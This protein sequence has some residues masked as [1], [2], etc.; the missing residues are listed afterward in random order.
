MPI[1]DANGQKL[2]YEIHGEGEPLLCVMGLGADSRA[3]VLQAPAFSQRHRTIIFDNRDVGQSSYVP[4]GSYEI[5]DM[6]ADALALADALDLESFHLLGVSMGGAI[7]QEMA[8]AAP[9]R[10]KTL[11][12]AVTWSSGG[13]YAEAKSQSWG[14]DIQ[15]LTFEEQIESMLLVLF[16]EAFFEQPERV[17]FV[18]NMLLSNPHPQEPEAFARQL[19]ACGRHT[20]ID[21]LGSLSMPVHVIGAEHDLLV[22]VWKSKEIA[23]AIPGAKLTIF[24]RAAH[25]VQF[26]SAEELNT[27][28]L[29][30]VGEY[31]AVAESAAP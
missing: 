18:R 12:L 15:K 1:A 28:V 13:R 30:F 7:S 22:P 14:R 19:D 29:G 8:L 23:D 6:A 17:E 21:R 2:Y 5:S 3:W 31:S 4:E 20:T 25:G 9:E 24:D 11:T 26:E 27:A 10:I 16:S